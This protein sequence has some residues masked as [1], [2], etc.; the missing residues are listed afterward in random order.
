QSRTERQEKSAALERT[1]GAFPRASLFR[2]D[3]DGVAFADAIDRQLERLDGCAS[4]LAVDRDESCPADRPSKNG[5][6]E[7]ADLGHE[8]DR[9][10]DR[11]EDAGNVEVAMVIGDQDVSLLPID[12]LGPLDS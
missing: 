12:D 7:E 3:D 6:L 11:L 9:L 1:H 8:S 2:K 4:I 10:G 5:D